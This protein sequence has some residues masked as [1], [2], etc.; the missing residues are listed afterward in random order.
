MKAVNLTNGA[1]R[2]LTLKGDLIR[3]GSGADLAN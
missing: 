1:V 2:N 3:Q